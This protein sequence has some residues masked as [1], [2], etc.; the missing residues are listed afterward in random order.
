MLRKHVAVDPGI[1]NTLVFV[2]S[3]D[4]VINE[5]S[6]AAVDTINRRVITMG[7]ETKD[8]IGRTSQRVSTIHPLRNGVIADFDVT[9]ALITAFLKK[10]IGSWPIKPD[11]VICVPTNITDV[12][13]HVVT[14]AVTKAGARN[15]KLIEEP[16]ATVVGAGLPVFGPVDSMVVDI[17]GGTADIAAITLDSMAY[18]ASPKLAGDAL[19]AAIQRFVQEK[20]QIVVGENTAEHI[21]ITFGSIAPLPV[22]LS[23]EVPGKDLAIANPRT[24]TL[25]DTDTHEAFQPITEK[26]VSAVMKILGVTPSRL[27]A[28]IMHQD[29]LLTG[30]GAL[31]R[32]FVDRITRATHI[33]VY[34][35]SGP[36]TTVPRGVGITLNDPEKYRDL[37]VEYWH[38]VPGTSKGSPPGLLGAMPG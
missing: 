37:L 38:G 29:M 4:I 20:Y 31:L 27:G 18:S 3:Q 17:G 25:S 22:S 23:F 15:V 36:L 30:G 8:C 24:V 10:V 6:V 12:E 7:K 11:M 34:V 35:D 16:A 19:T 13:R 33:P 28:D 32:G 1:A 9:Q 26:L 21:K 14:E 2:Q 5:P